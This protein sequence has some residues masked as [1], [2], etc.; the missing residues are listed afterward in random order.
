MDIQFL[1]TGS[2][3]RLPEY[4]C[5]CLICKKM[6]ELGQERTRTSIHVTTSFRI[7]ID[8]GPD[9]LTH[10]KRY[11]LDRP[12]MV[13]ITHEH[14]DHYLGMDELLVYRRAR[15]RNDWQPIPVYATDITWRI[16]QERF[17]YLV[18][19]L[20]E[21]RICE[22]GVAMSFGDTEIVPFKTVHGPTASGS[23]GYLIRQMTKGS[24]RCK[25]LIY[26][27]DFVEVETEIPEMYEADVLVIQSH[28]LNEPVENRPFHMSLQAGLRFIQKWKPTK[29]IFLVH[30]SGGDQVP[31]DPQNNTVKKA[32]PKEP[33]KAPGTNA[34]Y[35]VPLCQEDW[36]A[37][38]NRISID[39][40]IPCKM[41][42]PRD[43]DV[44]S[45]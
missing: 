15:E 3:W 12:D 17:G 33:M 22:P 6:N 43:G 10:M 14:G 42:V 4:S 23:V 20:I 7:L 38:L 21:K 11:N 9:L 8:P 39:Y 5:N 31:G 41:S 25:S 2:A 28:W 1:G 40:S 19:S 45:I 30:I 13:L 32:P 37:L 35:P 24:V 18:G 16:V 44:F 26:T 27:S 29:Q 36:D 34:V